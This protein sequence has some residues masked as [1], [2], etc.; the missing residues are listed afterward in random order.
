MKQKPTESKKEINNSTIIVSDFNISVLII[1]QLDRI[2]ARKEN[3]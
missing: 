2:S 3:I 1:E